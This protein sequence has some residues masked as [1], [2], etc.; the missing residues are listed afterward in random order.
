M[1]KGNIEIIRPLILLSD[2]DLSNY[3]KIKGF[4]PGIEDC[5]YKETNTRDK[6]RELVKDLSNLHE[7]AKINLY[8]SMQNINNDYLP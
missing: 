6:F 1:V 7:R 5:P 3:S 4:P 8:N 2:E